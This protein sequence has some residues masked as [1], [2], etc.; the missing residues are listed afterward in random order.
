M[1]RGNEVITNVTNANKHFASAFLMQILKFR[2]VVVS[3]SSFSR[4]AASAPRRAC[5]QATPAFN[6]ESG[7]F[8]WIDKKNFMHMHDE[9]AFVCKAAYFVVQ[10]MIPLFSRHL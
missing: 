7:L 10:T 9:V 2:D 5:S 1:P 3:S 6:L 4:P 8:F